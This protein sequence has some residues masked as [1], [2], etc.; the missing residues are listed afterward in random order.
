[1]DGRV[2]KISSSIFHVKNFVYR[3]LQDT[4]IIFDGKLFL[5]DFN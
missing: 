4:N 2:Y 5:I 1:M 3:N